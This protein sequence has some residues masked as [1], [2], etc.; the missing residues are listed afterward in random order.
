VADGDRILRPAFGIPARHVGHRD[1]HA[2]VSIVGACGLETTI[3]GTSSMTDATV[4]ATG[5]E[6]RSLLGSG[7]MRRH[8]PAPMNR[9]YPDL[10]LAVHSRMANHRFVSAGDRSTFARV[11]AE[12]GN[13]ML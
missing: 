1:Q 9:Q 7:E 8:Q 11:D 4:K 12:I 10:R 2:G 6:G 13:F 5:L 3:A